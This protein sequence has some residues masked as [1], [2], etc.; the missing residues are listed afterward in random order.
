MA[1]RALSPREKILIL[2]GAVLVFLAGMF[3][4]LLPPL[5]RLAGL[6]AEVARGRQLLVQIREL[7]AQEAALD[8]K[9]EELRTRLQEAGIAD[10]KAGFDVG[11]ALLLF[12]QVEATWGLRVEGLMASAEGT[13]VLV[14]KVAVAGGYRELA[15]CL[16]ALRAFPRTAQLDVTG[17][18]SVG[19]GVQADL[20]VRFRLTLRPPA[21]GPAAQPAGIRLRVPPLPALVGG[22]ENPFAPPP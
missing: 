22:R 8:R 2:A 5:M 9:L 3:T 6:R 20:Q 19:A 17:V 15:E 7:E 1:L 11:D 16:E 12:Q 18:T 10:P 21:P 14:A 4:L 13:E